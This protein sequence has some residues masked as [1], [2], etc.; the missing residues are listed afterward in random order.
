M[1]VFSK[2]GMF[3]A[4]IDKRDN[5]KLVVRSR[6]RRHLEMLLYRFDSTFVHGG[7]PPVIEEAVGTDYPYRIV[8]AKDQWADMLFAM[9]NEI[10]YTNFKNMSESRVR[11]LGR[12]YVD[13]L[14]EIWQA[15]WEA[16]KKVKC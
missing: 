1:W 2:Y 3:S 14:H 5:D 9:G 13:A 12:S 16:S 6:H 7:K 8:V 15:L 11:L 4:V 10:S